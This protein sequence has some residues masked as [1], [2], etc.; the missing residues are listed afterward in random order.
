[1]FVLFMLGINLGMVQLGAHL[2]YIHINNLL[3][4]FI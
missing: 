3:K 2:F 1:M 4:Y